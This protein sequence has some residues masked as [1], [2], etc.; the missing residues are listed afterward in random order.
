MNNIDTDKVVIEQYLKLYL[1][2]IEKGKSTERIKSRLGQLLTRY[3][4]IKTKS[5]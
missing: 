2:L 5:S 3:S 1:N 4:T